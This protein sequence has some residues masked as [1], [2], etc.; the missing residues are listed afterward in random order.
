MTF[1]SSSFTALWLLLTV[2]ATASPYLVEDIALPEGTP[3]EVGAIDFA[4]DGTLFLVLRRGDVFRAIPQADASNWQ[5]EYFATGFH[6]GCGIDALSRDC[7]RVTQMAEFT[8]ATD[9]DQ[10]GTAD[11]YRVF[12]NGWGLSGN[13]HET[14]ALTGDGQG[15][16]YLAIGT[17]SHNGPTAEFTLGEYSKFGRRG[18]NYSAVKWKGTTLHCDAEGK[19]TPFCY[20]FRM[21][22]GIHRDSAGHL[23]CGD[24]QGDWR[25][26]TPLYHLKKGG[27]YGHPNSLVWDPR[28][29]ADQDPLATFR[30]DLEGYNAYRT[31]PA[32]QIPHLEMNRSAGEP[33]VIPPQFPH[34]AGQMLLPD[35]N[36][37]R[38]TRI[39]LEEVAGEWQGACTHFL[40]EGGLRSGNH[41]LRFSP[42]GQALYIG[43]TVRGWGQPAEGLQRLTVKSDQE[44]FDVDQFSITPDGFQIRFTQELA[45][46]AQA[47]DFDF[48]SFTY[49]SKWTYGSPQENKAMHPIENIE[50]IDSRTLR[51]RLA[52]FT[53]GKVYQLNLAKLH[54]KEE[55]LIQNQLFYYTA[56][57]LPE[58]K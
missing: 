21:H 24:N 6:N 26:T 4:P 46:P 5:W 29:P 14:N 20:G 53:A 40:N 33:Y 17:A 41:R 30:A 3:P 15:G 42:D 55:A 27:F 50:A 39:M 34:F 22:N 31:L 25:A 45:E 11:Q 1:Q 18:R 7:V 38:I 36:G 28:W 13:Y 51:L 56:N 48:H 32:V 37:T 19:L 35:N 23:W 8:E 58:Q 44:P 2:F 54:S 47:S 9:T 52:D 10:D 12:S 16:Y 43:Q 49:Q 57:R